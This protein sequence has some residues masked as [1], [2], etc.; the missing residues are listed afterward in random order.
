MISDPAFYLAAIPAVILIGL[1]KGGFVGVGSLA[2]PLLAL[3]TS[4]IQG[5]AILLPLM[6][7]QDA[8]GVWAFRRNWDRTIVAVMLPGAAVGT[9]LGYLLARHVSV[10]AV[11]LALGIISISFAA[12]RLWTDRRGVITAPADSPKWVGSLFGVASGFTSQIALAGGP[13]FQMWVMPRRLAPARMAGTT[14]IYF[15][16]IN[17]MKIPAFTALG[18]FTRENLVT[19]VV[20]LPVAVLSTLC[21]VWLVRRIDAER[22]YV[23]IYVLMGVVGARL[24]WS[25]LT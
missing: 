3:A 2:L 12:H 9:L 4:P 11:M 1:G 21:G 25:A 7:V 24:V 23:A 8:V 15:A 22:F 18:Q 6:I 20:L 16:V 5:A 14:A 19:S 17:W 13:P 10:D